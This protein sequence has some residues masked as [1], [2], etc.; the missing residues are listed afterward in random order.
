[1]GRAFCTRPGRAERRM[2]SAP[3]SRSGALR[4]GWRSVYCAVIRAQSPEH[5]WE[6]QRAAPVRS[7]R[8]GNLDGSG[9]SVVASHRWSWTAA[10]V[11]G[12][13][14]VGHSGPDHSQ[15]ELGR[16]PKGS[17]A[18]TLLGPGGGHGV[19]RPQPDGFIQLLGPSIGGATSIVELASWLCPSLLSRRLSAR[20]RMCPSRLP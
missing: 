3:D 12:R 6:P 9:G 7:A 13:G 14:G 10:G 17:D 15:S 4:T 16:Q 11:R 2:R 8:R 20:H 5:P 18:R 19:F 1:M